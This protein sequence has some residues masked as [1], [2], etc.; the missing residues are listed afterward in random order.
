MANKEYNALK[1]LIEKP[2]RKENSDNR[3]GYR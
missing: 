1:P 2:R 3:N